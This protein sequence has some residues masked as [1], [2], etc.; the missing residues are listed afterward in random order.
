MNGQ[1]MLERLGREG[2]SLP[3]VI[4]HTASDFTVQEEMGLREH[5]DS[6]VI[7]DARSP[8]RLLDEVAL[9]LHRVVSE[10]PE[11]K[12]KIIRD[13]HDTNA[14]LRDKKVLIV[15]DDMRTLFAVSRLLSERG[16]Q[17]IKAENGQL[18]LQLLDDNPD[19]DLILMDIMMP[20]LDGYEAMQRIRGQERYRKLPIIALTAKAMPEDRQ[21]C[22]AAGASDYLTKP[23]DAD[24]LFSMMRVWLYG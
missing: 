1:A 2:V 3:P 17:A 19:I 11:P 14:L 9:F 24:R 22:I 16:L 12:R 23:I 13:L 7:K 20:V 10:M 8:E 18:A 4:V 15:D 6:I 21:K 5:A